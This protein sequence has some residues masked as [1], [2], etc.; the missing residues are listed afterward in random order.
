MN[1]SRS[2]PH[3]QNLLKMNRGKQTAKDFIQLWI[4]V[5]VLNHI[6]HLPTHSNWK[7]LRVDSSRE[8][9]VKR[10][11]TDK[12]SL[13]KTTKTY[14]HDLLLATF[15]YPIHDST[16][17]IIKCRESDSGEEWKTNSKWISDLTLSNFAAK[18]MHTPGLGS[19]R[20]SALK[21]LLSCVNI[22]SSLG[23]GCE[24]SVRKEG[25]AARYDGRIRRGTLYERSHSNESLPERYLLLFPFTIDLNIFRGQSQHNGIS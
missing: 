1:T 15:L 11:K 12:S 2:S 24:G 9:D 5:F 13:E 21:F 23:C 8:D 18:K 6:E 7:Y 10:R 19:W 25:N 16:I 14:W 22:L 20:N 3:V 4:S 17:N